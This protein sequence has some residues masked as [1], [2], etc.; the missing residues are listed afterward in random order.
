MAELLTSRELEVVRLLASRLDNEEIAQRL[1][2]SPGTAKIHIHH[3]YMKL[4]VSGR[5]E[6]QNYLKTAGY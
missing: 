6:L 5:Q 1:G 3:V 4:G 2:I